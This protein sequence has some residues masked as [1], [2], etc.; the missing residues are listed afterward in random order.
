MKDLKEAYK[1]IEADHFAPRMEVS[2][3]DGDKRE[4][5]SYEKVTWN[6]GG[7]EKG[8]RYGENPGQEAALYKLVN[9]NLVLGEVEMLGANQPLASIPELLQSGKHP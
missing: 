4:T 5:L 2:F 8:L 7:E 3:I 1:T 9:G 6:I